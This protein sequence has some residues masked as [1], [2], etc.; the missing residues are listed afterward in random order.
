MKSN[1]GFTLVEI[2]SA[3]I[4]LGIIGAIIYPQTIKLIDRNK[5]K[6]FVEALEGLKR[7]YDTY[8]A[9]INYKDDTPFDLETEH[10]DTLK[11]DKWKSGTITKQDDGYYFENVYDGEFCANGLEGDYTITKGECD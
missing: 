7:S 1:K 10:I 3:L 11:T 5:E 6:S 9:S 8:L 2:L 4:I